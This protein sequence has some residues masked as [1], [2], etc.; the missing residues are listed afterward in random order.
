MNLLH[1][2]PDYTDEEGP[3]VYLDGSALNRP[4][5]MPRQA[6]LIMLALVVCAIIIGVK[7][8]SDAIGTV[9]GNNAA[10]KASLEQNLTKQ[11]SYNIPAMSTLVNADN[12]TILATFESEGLTIYNQTAEGDSGLDVV[13][14]P[15][16][17]TLAEAATMYAK[18]VSSLSAANAARLLNG[19]W[20]LSIDRSDSSQSIA[21]KYADFT[22]SSIEAAISSAIVQ[23]GFDAS[24]T[25]QD[26]TGTDDMGNT[27]QTGTIDID[28]STYNWRV[29]ATALS[30]KYN[31]SGLPES[32]VFVGIRLNA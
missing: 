2:K 32:A 22:A 31:I 6:R 17:V 5:E 11:V 4:I 21:I 15:P 14:L 29:S 7:I 8:G 24:T 19:S 12:E 23:A 10:S 20:T 16:D 3:V 28:G 13:K 30:N 9:V 1:T 27:Y 25:P 26:G 18:G